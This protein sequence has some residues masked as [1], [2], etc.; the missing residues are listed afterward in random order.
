MAH[1]VSFICK[2]T[3]ISTKPVEPRKFSP[4]SVL[5]RIM[6]RSHLC[7]VLYYNLPTRRRPGELTKQLKESISEMLSSFPVVVGRLLRTPEGQWSI[8]C[9][10]AGVRL[11]EAKVN[12]TVEE[13]LH[14]VDSEKE[15]SL[16][17]WEEMS[18]KPYFWSPF[19]VQ[20]HF[21]NQTMHPKIKWSEIGRIKKIGS[22]SF[23][24]IRLRNYG[25][26]NIKNK[27]YEESYYRR[28]IGNQR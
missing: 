25:T 5:D 17:H 23:K 27:E 9:N 8:K 3:V 24:K 28:H 19:Y 15:L 26:K 22:H 12:S 1:Q 10:D 21:T 11:V 16:V 18:H 14:N 4:L 2:R 7:I 13:W 20:V 6:E